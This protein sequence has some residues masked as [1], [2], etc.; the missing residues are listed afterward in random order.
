M[1]AA[2]FNGQF[3]SVA[4]VRKREGILF[5]L[6]E[7]VCVSWFINGAVHLVKPPARPRQ[8]ALTAAVTTSGRGGLDFEFHLIVL[9][10]FSFVATRTISHRG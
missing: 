4:P 9:H 2:V 1:A 7:H 6:A 5:D 10:K 3:V 8:S